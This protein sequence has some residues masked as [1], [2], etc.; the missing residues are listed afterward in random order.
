[1]VIIT[2]FASK[3]LGKSLK[4]YYLVQSKLIVRSKPKLTLRLN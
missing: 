2:K 4:L 3:I 1:M